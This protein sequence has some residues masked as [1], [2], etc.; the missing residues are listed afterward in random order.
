MYSWSLSGGAHPPNPETSNNG[1]INFDDQEFLPCTNLSFQ[2]KLAF[3][4]N[5]FHSGLMFAATQWI[6]EKPQTGIAS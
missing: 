5:S 1:L 6:Q 3:S 2:S 4:T